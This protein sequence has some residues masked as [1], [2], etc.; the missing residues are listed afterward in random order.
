MYWESKIPKSQ[1]CSSS[2]SQ[3]FTVKHYISLCITFH[4]QTLHLHNIRFRDKMS[5]AKIAMSQIC[6]SAI[7]HL[8]A[9]NDFAHHFY[10]QTTSISNACW[11]SSCINARFR[12]SFF[13]QQVLLLSQKSQTRHNPLTL[14]TNIKQLCAYTIYQPCKNPF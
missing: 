7:S 3:L 1:L 11:K 5:I 14:N 8:A 4:A 13:A 9:D 12:F 2:F 6:S 10:A